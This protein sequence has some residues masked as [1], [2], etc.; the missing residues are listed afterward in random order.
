MLYCW[1]GDPFLLFPDL[2]RSKQNSV[3]PTTHI[4]IV[5]CVGDPR[6]LRLA[7]LYAIDVCPKQGFAD[8]RKRNGPPVK[9]ARSGVEAWFIFPNVSSRDQGSV[10][11]GGCRGS[12]VLCPLGFS[13][14]SGVGFLEWGVA[15]WGVVSCPLTFATGYIF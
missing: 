2:G 4:N 15:S 1:R 5:R 6:G 8:N 9:M 14:K 12:V 3:R 10:I 13:L 7:G 11:D